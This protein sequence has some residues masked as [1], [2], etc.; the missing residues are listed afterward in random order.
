[1]T[2]TYLAQVVLGRS[3]GS[4]SLQL[5]LLLPGGGGGSERAARF[6]TMPYQSLSLL[7]VGRLF[8]SGPARITPDANQRSGTRTAPICTRVT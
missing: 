6:L 1:M 3:S 4:L 7:T 8:F 5:L 2:E